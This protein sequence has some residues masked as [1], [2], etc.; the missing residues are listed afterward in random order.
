MEIAYFTGQVKY[1]FLLRGT[2]RCHQELLASL[3]SPTSFSMSEKGS[4]C[5]FLIEEIGRTILKKQV[6]SRTLLVH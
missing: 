5:A 2:C 3:L 1:V 6:M 4:E